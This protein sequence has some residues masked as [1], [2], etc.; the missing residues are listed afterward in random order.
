M[1]AVKMGRD[2]VVQRTVGGGKSGAVFSHLLVP[3]IHGKVFQDLSGDLKLQCQTLYTMFFFF[4]LIYTYF[5]IQF[6]S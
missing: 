1:T 3:F 5:Q 4:L 6:I 2:P